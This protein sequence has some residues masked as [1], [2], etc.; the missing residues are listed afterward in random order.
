L[1][2]RWTQ[3]NYNHKLVEFTTKNLGFGWVLPRNM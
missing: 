3:G 2:F 1:R